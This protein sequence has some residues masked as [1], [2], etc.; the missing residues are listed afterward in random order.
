MYIQTVSFS[1]WV[2]DNTRK[3]KSRQNLTRML[4]HNAFVEYYCLLMNSAEVL[5]D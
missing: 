1:V 4:I 2:T 5:H 3:K